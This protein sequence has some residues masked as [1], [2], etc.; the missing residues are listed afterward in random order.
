MRAPMNKMGVIGGK[1]QTKSRR[2]FRQIR[3]NFWTV[4]VEF[5]TVLDVNST[6]YGE[7]VGQYLKT[8]LT[9]KFEFWV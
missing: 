6:K 2:I 1:A 8:F 7:T 9:E 3:V 5:G 4:H